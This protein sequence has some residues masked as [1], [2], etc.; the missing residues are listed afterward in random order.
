VLLSGVYFPYWVTTDTFTPFALVG[1]AALWLAAEATRRHAHSVRLAAMAAVLAGLAQWI[2]PDAALLLVAPLVA[3]AWTCR[4]WAQPRHRRLRAL[5]PVGLAYAAGLAPWL[6]RNWQTWGAL[7]PPGTGAALWLRD[8]DDLFAFAALPSF[9]RWRAAGL[10]TA[11]LARPSALLANLG[12]LGQPLLYYLVP[13][14]LFGLWRLRRRREFWPVLAYVVALYLVFSLVFPF[15]G[16]RGGLFHSLAAAVPFLA[17]WTVVG[18]EG[19]V[20]AAARRRR[21][22]EPQA[23]QVFAGALLAFS[24]ISSVYFLALQTTRWDAR[25]VAYQQIAGLLARQVSPDAR[26]LVVDPPG[27]WYA[28]GREAAVIPSDGFGALRSAAAAFDVRYLVVEESGP[29]YLAPLWAGTA[30]VPGFTCIGQTEQASVY[31][32]D[33]SGAQP[34]AACP[35]IS[36]HD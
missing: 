15:Q 26:V 36:G 5:V 33:P 30:A 6:I 12:V 20:S 23:Q 14:T 32:V 3:L 18:L 31:A 4:A 29:A 2:R 16:V 8:Y 7:T 13:L 34:A 19:A 22:I 9:A 28:S 1:G 10:G 24:A 35:P 27:F 21:W 17:V 11:L 25:L